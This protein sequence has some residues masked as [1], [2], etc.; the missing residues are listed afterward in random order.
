[1]LDCTLIGLNE[2]NDKTKEF[3]G[4]NSKKLFQS[5]KWLEVIKRAYGHKAYILQVEEGGKAKFV[6]PFVEIRNKIISLPF[7][8]YSFPIVED[9]NAKHISE[10]KD[11]LKNNDYDFSIRS[12]DSN[13]A[14]NDLACDRNNLIQ[15]L[16]LTESVD[17]Q[18]KGFTDKVRNQVRKAEKSGIEIKTDEKYLNE[19]WGLWAAHI[20]KLG[21]P[22]H[23]L[24]FFDEI[25]KTFDTQ[26][27]MLIT[28]WYENKIAGGMILMF[29]EDTAYVPWASSL[30]KLKPL[31]INHLLY[32]EAIK[33]SIKREKKG[34]DFLRSQ[35]GTGP[36]N[37]KKQW[38]TEERQL[39]YYSNK[40]NN[41]NRESKKAKI[42]INVW[43]NV[44]ASI[45]KCLGPRLRKYIP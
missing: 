42:F 27:R 6:L 30:D 21:T 29:D 28:A 39:F 16:K 15:I 4:K 41:I 10:A 25:F 22:S 2:I 44:P 26:N 31:C 43:K 7:V 14:L 34:F 18:W 35:K 8:D 19:F 11:F 17:E 40:D 32:W 33:E 9:E 24:K 36:Y 5:L 23:S 3:V 1:M 13:D 12:L 45:A 38:G 37:F 20:N